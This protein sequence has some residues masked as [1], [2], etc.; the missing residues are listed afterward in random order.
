[1]PSDQDHKIEELLKASAQRRRQKAGAPFEMHPATRRLL[2]AEVARRRPGGETKSP[3]LIELLMRSWP[4]FTLAASVIVAAGILILL[5]NPKPAA[6][7]EMAQNTHR[8]GAEF[9]AGQDRVKKDSSAPQPG[10]APETA[11]ALGGRERDEGKPNSPEKLTL[12]D[13]SLTRDA[14]QAVNSPANQS[15]VEGGVALSMPRLNETESKSRQALED[16]ASAKRE[17]AAPAPQPIGKAA[18]QTQVTE[19]ARFSQMVQAAKSVRVQSQAQPVL[20]TSFEL[21]QNGNSIR[22]FDTDGSVYEGQVAASA[23]AGFGLDAVAT[24]NDKAKLAL[25]VNEAEKAQAA[26]STPTGNVVAVVQQRNAF[27]ASGTNRS[28]NQLVRIS[29]SFISAADAQT[30]SFGDLPALRGSAATTFFQSAPATAPAAAP[31]APPAE[32]RAFAPAQRA[33]APA[34]ARQALE[35]QSQTTS[36]PVLQ[37][38]GRAKVGPSNEVEINAFRIPR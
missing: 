27:Q 11:K 1:M 3:S 36:T 13:R 17:L 18:A 33:D 5:S 19:R 34:R 20:L 24:A 16:L 32:S 4:R 38:L 6:R 22:I 14:K 31:A 9:L 8:T 10:N 26:P 35:P 7:Q 23:S 30:R 2:Q 15:G 28:L 25:T 29:G 37:I 12:S 21:E